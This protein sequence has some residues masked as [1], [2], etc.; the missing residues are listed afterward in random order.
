MADDPEDDED[1]DRFESS[2]LLLQSARENIDN[3]KAILDAHFTPD[4]YFHSQEF[5]PKT[6]LVNVKVK[7]T[8][9]LPTTVRLRASAAI[10]DLRHAL[11]Q[12]CFAAC[13]VFKTGAD[14]TYFPFATSPSDLETVFAKRAKQI[15]LPIREVIRSFEPYPTADTHPGGNN[16]LRVLGHISGP[17]KHRVIVS[18]EANS[19][20][21]SMG[22]MMIIYP[23]A[24]EMP[25]EWNRSKRELI[26][27]RYPPWAEPHLDL[28]P[29]FRVIFI[30][31]EV[32]RLNGAP[33]FDVLMTL[34]PIV[35]NIVTAIEQGTLAAKLGEGG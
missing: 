35:T 15:P 7:L 5:D 9:A 13:Q 12:A 25:L 33:V 3:I 10:N 6:G 28:N 23:G 34:L 22:E 26:I 24:F 19:N 14:K 18:A 8:R 21:V 16:A 31:R 4:L 32:P 17:N 29:E 11:D 30:D 20:S 1:H 2:K 27:A